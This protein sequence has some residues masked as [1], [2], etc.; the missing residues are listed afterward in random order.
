MLVFVVGTL[1]AHGHRTVTAAL[2]HMGLHRRSSWAPYHHVLNRSV[3]SPRTVSRILLQLV[4]STFVG[5][6]G[7][8]MVIDETLERRWGRKIRRRCHWRDSRLSSRQRHVTT[9]GLRWVVMAVVVTLPWTQQR[10]AL[11]FLSV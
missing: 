9:S 11:P 6:G 1:L 10:W 7:V 8:D 2:R 3:W 5:V 4:V